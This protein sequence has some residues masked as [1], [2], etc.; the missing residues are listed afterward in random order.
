MVVT[1]EQLN[2]NDDQVWDKTLGDSPEKFFVKLDPFFLIY[3]PFR[4]FC[5]V[6]VN[7]L[8][9]IKTFSC[10]KII[11]VSLGTSAPVKI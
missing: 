3:C 11:L 5:V 7:V 9:F 1:L 8:F 2:L 6:L 4:G 10:N